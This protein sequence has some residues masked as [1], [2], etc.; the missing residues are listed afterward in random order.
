MFEQLKFF[1]K[2]LPDLPTVSQL[3][4]PPTGMMLLYSLTMLYSLTNLTYTSTRQRQ[5]TAGFVYFK[6][7]HFQ[8]LWSDSIDN[9][10]FEQFLSHPSFAP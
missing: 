1:E 9:V 7:H 3:V 10:Q 5:E 6:T 2:M 8:T 4:Q